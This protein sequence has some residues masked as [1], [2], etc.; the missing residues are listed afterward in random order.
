MFRIDLQISSQP[1]VLTD[2]DGDYYLSAT[3]T[4]YVLSSTCWTKNI[5]SVPTLQWL[6]VFNN[7]E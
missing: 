3:G 2:D 7:V 6:S 1:E 5:A 4:P